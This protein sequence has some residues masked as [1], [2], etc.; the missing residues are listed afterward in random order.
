M[1][2]I[3]FIFLFFLT[4]QVTA[5]LFY[6]FEQHSIGN[7]KQSPENRWE[8]S[9]TN[10]IN[11][12]FSLHHYYDN[13]KSSR[14][15]ISFPHVFSTQG[16]STVWRFQVRYDYNPSGSNNWSVF[17]MA[18]T[19]A[20]EM[21]PSGTVNGYVVGVNYS[22]SDDFVKLWKIT[23]GSGYEVIA[24]NFN[25]QKEI[26]SGT[27]VG[28][29]IR[30]NGAG[31]WEILIDTDGNFDNLI[32]IGTESNADYTESKHCGIYYEYTSSADQKLWIDDFYV[33]PPVEDTVPPKIQSAEIINTHEILVAYSEAMDTS[34]VL[35]A[36][37]YVLDSINTPASTELT[38]SLQKI[39]KL[40]FTDSFTDSSAHQLL[41]EHAEDTS[42]NFLS[43]ISCSLFYDKMKVSSV[44]TL[45]QNTIQV[46]F[47]KTPVPASA[48]DP[49]LY[50]L[51]P[52]S[53][54]P[55]A[56]T[57]DPENEKI[58]TLTFANDF[59]E[60]TNTALSI[61]AVYD[62]YGDEM[63]PSIHKFKIVIANENDIVINEIMADPYPPVALP[64]EE[65][66]E[67]YNA[68]S[69]EI[70]LAN[71][72]LEINASSK[73]FPA[74]KIP[75]QS[76][77]LLCDK[78]VVESMEDYGKAIGLSAFPNL[79]NS[80][81]EIT[82]KDTSG[83]I[84]NTVAYTDQWY[85]DADKDNGGYSL[86]KIDPANNCSGINNWQASE[87]S[88]GGTPGE[89]NSVFGSNIDTT[90]PKI[91]FIELKHNQ[92]ITIDFS[93]TVD[94]SNLKINDFVVS[95][96]I[97]NPYSI[98]L[99]EPYNNQIDLFFAKPIKIDKQYE[100]Q[101]VNISDLCGNSVSI[102][103]NI[104]YHPPQANEIQINEIMAK[105]SPPVNLPNAE[106]VELY[107]ASPYSISLNNWS[108]TAG[109]STRNIGKIALKPN[110]YLIL[111][112]KDYQQAFEH[113]GQTYAFDGMPAISQSGTFVILETNKK[114]I[115]SYISFDE[116][117]YP[118]EY[119]Q[120]GGWSLEQIDPENP[121][122]EGDNWSASENENGGTPG[123]L[124][125]IYGTNKDEQAPILLRA[126]FQDSSS[127]KL[128]F[129]ETLDKNSLLNK[130]KYTAETIGHPIYVIP[131]P[132]DYKSVTLQFAEQFQSN[133]R[134]Q[135]NVTDT[136][137][138]CAGNISDAKQ[139]VEFE[140]P[141]PIKEGDL[142]INE[143]LFNPLDGGHDFVEIFNNTNKTLNLTQLC[144]GSGND[145]K[146]VFCMEN[147]EY[148]IFPET[149][150]VITENPSS[151]VRDYYVEQPE[152]LLKTE[153]LPAY[154]NS[155]GSV[156][157]MNKSSTIIDKMNYTED[158]HFPLLNDTKGV[159]LERTHY[160]RPS[161][162]KSTWHSAAESSGFAT[163]TYKNSQFS[164]KIETKMDFKIEPEVFS[165]DN[166]GRDDLLNI[167]YTLDEPGHVA[168]IKIF[169][170]RGR[171]EKNLINNKTL[172][173]EGI[174]TWDGINKNNKKARIGIYVVFI[175]VFDQNG[176]VSKTKKH[177]VVGGKL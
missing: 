62:A 20:E 107:N 135:I 35:D 67:L 157:L 177:C 137:K 3:L 30:N 28:L 38:D 173:T 164:K 82:I 90:A 93:E 105:P 50:E 136:I 140:I 49:S 147:Y 169:D 127:V 106:Y 72:T 172:G 33:G 21:H 48:T 166:D 57:I 15:R 130:E 159:S 24:T 44:Q 113:Y 16:H 18:D 29:E 75:P 40:R 26:N 102:K 99:N 171:L 76:Y 101:S 11:G 174:I 176:N 109:R 54:Q 79:I 58:L 70:D 163:P 115:I 73:A 132:P 143:V 149:H 138:D 19:T 131:N 133:I 151:L 74:T 86:E 120:S 12:A 47:N 2:N 68:T 114:E 123:T 150:F 1:K 155:S 104:V 124:N 65:Y 7:W 156:F 9:N 128:H 53:Y 165:P 116:S 42:A 167:H 145:Y 83:N 158:M 87:A 146:D 112:D 175:E 139:S 52:G 5:Q 92:Q 162:E 41:I 81:A 89:K 36:E 39:I 153:K 91:T 61:G 59:E 60:N 152:H 168:N 25:W 23:S 161:A 88:I 31:K 51:T 56:I 32:S 14:D 6:N 122:G 80:S 160:D 77:L 34:S 8:I 45:S 22:G 126:S 66:I 13:S 144:I 108:F 110:S 117:W 69:E 103:Q 129:N 63:L 98:S 141:H 95:P 4:T 71:W 46:T 121:C 111:C 96:D 78:N 84:I 55:K 142:V 154:R 85:Q 43:D 119:K 64:E 37:N 148:L 125:S 118:N 10:P 134:Y 97:G 170:S 27:I 94:T 100:I 17:L